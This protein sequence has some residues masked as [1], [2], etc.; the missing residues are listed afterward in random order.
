M[1]IHREAL[2]LAKNCA[3]DDDGVPF[4]IT[5][6][7][8]TPEGAVTVTDGRHWLRMKASADVPNL[9]DDIAE[10]GNG[11]LEEPVLIPGDVV[12][13]FSAAMKKKKVKK[14]TPAPHVAVSQVGP[15]VTRT[16]SDGKTTRKFLIDGVAKELVFPNVD[17]TV[18]AHVPERTV[19]FGVDL[20]AIIVRTLKA[21]KAD[22]V[23]FGFP[24]STEGPIT[25]RATTETG[26]ISGAGMPYA[27]PE[28]AENA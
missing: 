20:L 23:Q 19:R 24:S 14:G 27:D 7:H 15:D 22:T 5:C 2:E 16:S 1:L 25:I 11:H 8:I 6:V 9:F 13:S 3:P 21:C 18:L 4:T 26:P 12:T 17:K 10:R 28:P